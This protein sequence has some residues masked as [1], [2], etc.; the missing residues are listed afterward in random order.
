[1]GKAEKRK[2]NP[3]LEN[4]IQVMSGRCLIDVDAVDELYPITVL[5]KAV[6]A[7]KQYKSHRRWEVDE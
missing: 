3:V 4:C 5:N 7:E 6:P 2:R 1:L